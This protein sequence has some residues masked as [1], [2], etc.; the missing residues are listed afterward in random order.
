MT[1]RAAITQRS[2]TLEV[3]WTHDGKEA[4][5][6]RFTYPTAETA[7]EALDAILMAVE[8]HRR[9]SRPH[10]ISG[11]SPMGQSPGG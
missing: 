8:A 2:D 10:A 1:C 6:L 9:D 5:I 11:D 3:I 7:S 4:V